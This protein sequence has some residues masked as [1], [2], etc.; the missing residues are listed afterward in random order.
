MT[1]FCHDSTVMT[2]FRHNTQPKF[3]TITLFPHMPLFRHQRV[4]AG[5]ILRFFSQMFLPS[6][7]ASS[8]SLVCL[9]F[10]LQLG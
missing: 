4:H 9:A 10:K 8:A 7:M 1:F 3:A 5:K 2:L 6:E